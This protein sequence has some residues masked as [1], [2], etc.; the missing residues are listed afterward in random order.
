MVN[1]V[2]VL[3]NRQLTYPRFYTTLKLNVYNNSPWE[4]F[5]SEDCRCD[6]AADQVIAYAQS[7]ID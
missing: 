5:S 6:E 3:N 4:K 2:A 7:M 1:T